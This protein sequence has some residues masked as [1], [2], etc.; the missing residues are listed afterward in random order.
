VG[1]LA[2][3]V[4]VYYQQAPKTTPSAGGG[5]PETLPETIGTTGTL[6]RQSIH[7]SD[8]MLFK[9]LNVLRPIRNSPDIIDIGITRLLCERYEGGV[10][11]HCGLTDEQY[12][13]FINEVL[14][15]ITTGF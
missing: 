13:A 9:G 7:F 14:D 1:A 10:F 4:I 8:E 2:L 11:E 6:P 12:R 15:L 5:S 3:G